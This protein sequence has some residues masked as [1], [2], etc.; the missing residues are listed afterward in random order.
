MLD[1][2]IGSSEPIRRVQPE[3]ETHAE[4]KD[5]KGRDPLFAVAFNGYLQKEKRWI[6]DIDYLHAENANHARLQWLFAHQG[7]RFE[8]IAVGLVVG[9]YALDDNGD[10]LSV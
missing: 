3:V 7:Q 4:G 9:Y 1:S 2:D 5:A 10:E 6:A 8:I